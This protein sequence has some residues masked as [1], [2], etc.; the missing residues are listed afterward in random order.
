MNEVGITA[1]GGYIPRLRM[2][3]KSIV[4]ANIWVDPSLM[5]H[6]KSE[7]SMCDYDEDT[8]TMA[9]EAGR[10]CLKEADRQDIDAVFF[11]S[12]TMPFDDRQNSTVVA[13]ALGIKENIET[14]DVSH[15]QRAATSGMIT[16]MKALAGGEGKASLFVAS[17]QRE[18]KC[19]TPKELLYGD[20]AA[21][22]TL[23]KGDGL[24]AR[25]LGA[26]SVSRDMVDHFRS[27]GERFDYE[28]EERWIREEGYFKIVPSAIKGLLEKTGVAPGE[29]DHFV[30]PCVIKRV[31]ETIAKKMGMPAEAIRD[32]LMNGCGETGSAHAVVMLVDA[33]QDAK[34]GEKILVVGFGQGADALLFETTEAVSKQTRA[35]GIKGGMKNGIVEDN[36][37]KF[38]SFR[39]LVPIEWGMRAEAGARKTRMTTLYRNR[40]MLNSLYGGKCSECGTIQFPKA[41]ICVN[42]ECRAVDSMDDYSLAES[43][44]KIASYTVDWLAYTPNPPLLFGMI[45]FEEGA[46]FMMQFTGCKPEEVE[47]GVPMEM[48]FRIKT[49]DDQ[50]KFKNYFWK[51]TPVVDNA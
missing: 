7:R 10:D 45:E 36:Y 11:A 46:K 21:A 20:G 38:L 17:E 44:S 33:L 26:Y 29:I 24:I 35:K 28:W 49:D 51:A 30:L 27:K 3:R 32:N 1:Y 15:S 9:V 48:V 37:Q 23:G 19:G 13:E 12:T 5:A 25:Y 4:Q 39:N 14:L 22:V 16:A 18:T 40:K 43:K 42:P 31:R 8:I 2:S 34:P 50:L 47:V 41:H 6:A